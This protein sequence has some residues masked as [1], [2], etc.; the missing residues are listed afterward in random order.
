MRN[1]AI[2]AHP[3]QWQDVI[4]VCRKCSKKLKGGFGADG[5]QT[6]VRALKNELRGTP[7]RRS[8][9]LIETKCLG[10]CPKNAVTV[11]SATHPAEILTIPAGL[12]PVAV[13]TRLLPAPGPSPLRTSVPSAA[14]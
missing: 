4:L 9:H 5:G 11:L 8:T 10:I 14:P 6:L 2:E 12:D 1:I 3:T 7:A 13:V